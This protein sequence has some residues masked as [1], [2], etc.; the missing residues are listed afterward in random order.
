MTG[1]THKTF[2][3]F[4]SDWSGCTNVAFDKVGCPGLGAHASCDIS[5]SLTLTRYHLTLIILKHEGD[6]Q[7]Q[8]HKCWSQ[9]HAGSLGCRHRGE[10][11][12]SQLFVLASIA[13]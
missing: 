1:V 12:E 10:T 7:V 6:Q 5:A 9:G 8:G 2:D 11:D 3:T 13:R 4:A